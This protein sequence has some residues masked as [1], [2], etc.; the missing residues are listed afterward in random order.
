MFRKGVFKISANYWNFPY[1]KILFIIQNAFLVF[2]FMFLMLM[3]FCLEYLKNVMTFITR[4][5]R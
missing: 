4:F 3:F 1:Y 5:V 2:D